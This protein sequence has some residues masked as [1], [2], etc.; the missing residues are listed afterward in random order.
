MEE[1]IVMPENI[2]Q[3][4][5]IIFVVVFVCIPALIRL[6]SGAQEHINMLEAE[7]QARRRSRY[8]F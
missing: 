7:D 8:G 3:V 1:L 4:G 2:V 6:G 5:I